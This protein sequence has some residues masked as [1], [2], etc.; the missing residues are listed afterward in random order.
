[1]PVL[2]SQLG[3]RASKRRGRQANL[4]ENRMGEMDWD[5][6]PKTN[7]KIRRMSWEDVR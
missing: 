4:L 6:W 1:M 3:L 7:M 5:S 2:T